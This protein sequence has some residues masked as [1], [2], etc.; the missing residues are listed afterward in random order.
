MGITTGK[1][2]FTRYGTEHIPYAAKEEMIKAAAEKA[3]IPI[4]EAMALP[5]GRN[6]GFAS[7]KVLLDCKI[8]EENSLIDGYVVLNVR[9]TEKKIN[10]GMLKAIIQREEAAY[11]KAN[12]LEFVPRRVRNQIKEDAVDRLMQTAPLSVKGTEVV[13]DG[14]QLIIGAT[15]ER[16]CYTVCELLLKSLGVVPEWKKHT[17]A[18]GDSFGAGRKFLTWLFNCVKERV[19]MPG[20]VQVMIEGPLELLA[21]DDCDSA[22]KGNCTKAKLEGGTVANS[23]ELDTAL[24]IK[25]TIRKAKLALVKGDDVWKFT[26]D[27]DAWNFS[28]MELPKECETFA[29]RMDA[30]RELYDEMEKLFNTWKIAQA[31]E[32]GIVELPNMEKK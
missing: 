15:S 11:M 23:I 4:S 30:I 22:E 21:P 17:D 7:G 19:S 26:F 9:Q 28:G 29:D 27:A 5:D 14:E 8:S 12:C 1:L 13:F 31:T 18:T 6:V 10:A 3:A 20:F 32:L 16:E 2:K 24:A 25:K